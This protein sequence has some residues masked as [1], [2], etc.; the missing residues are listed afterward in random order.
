MTNRFELIL[1][2]SRPGQCMTPCADGIYK[3]KEVFDTVLAK[4]PIVWLTKD[5]EMRLWKSP[6]NRNREIGSFE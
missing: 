4:Q 1:T 5:F 3:L 2:S 6:R